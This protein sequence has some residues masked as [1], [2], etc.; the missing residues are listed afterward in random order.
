M[1][2]AG[3]LGNSTATTT[4]LTRLLFSVGFLTL[5]MDVATAL[6]KPPRGVV[7]ERHTLAGIFA[8][9]LAE[10]STAFWVASSGQAKGHLVM[11]ARVLLCSSV[12][13]LAAVIALGGFSV[14]LKN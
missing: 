5:I 8:A 7:F 4:Q 2:A 11:F 3:D 13:P 1:G 10:V 14:L 12:I 9:R 6:Y